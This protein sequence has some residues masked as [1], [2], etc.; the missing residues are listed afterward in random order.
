MMRST[1][2]NKC[3]SRSSLFLMLIPVSLGLA[4]WAMADEA[5]SPLPVSE[6]NRTTSVDFNT[7]ILPLLKQN[8]LAC[9]H[10]KEAE[11]GLV[12]ETLDSILKGGDSGP[13]LVAGKSAES[14][15]FSRAVG[16]DDPLM[17]PEDN[18]VG[19]KP[20]NPEQLG[21]LKLWIDQGAAAGKAKAIETITWQPIPEAMRT[22]YAL[23]LSP[24]GQF[25]VVGRGNRVIVVD[26]ATHEVQSRLVDPSLKVGEV[27]DV[28]LIQ[29]VAISPQADFIATGG[30]RTVRLWHKTARVYPD[31]EVPFGNA[32]G[33][34]AVHPNQELA[35]FVNAIGDIEVWNLTEN[36]RSH[37]LTG[38]SERI[39]DLAWAETPDALLSVDEMGNITQW[40]LKT[41][42]RKIQYDAGPLTSMTV[43]PDGSQVALINV[44]G[45]PQLLR[46]NAEATG[47]E[48][49]QESLGGL[50]EATAIAFVAKPSLMTVVATGNGT[51]SFV[52]VADNKIV[53]KVEHGAPVTAIEISGDQ[54]R[55]V[56]NSWRTAEIS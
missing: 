11:G 15:L 19:A 52:N 2:A 12:L 48:L 8:C 43:T 51:V 5:D 18:S 28:D 29:S 20:L 56:Q 26:T 3:L 31:S 9:H 45:K 50:T 14:L 54:L 53:R 34:I 24:D 17:P 22:V 13:A 25:A 44:E 6:L 46:I 47:F 10:A 40:D 55:S 36:Q 33:V 27:T 32:A 39:I 23:Q 1:L 49:Q 38:N 42:S 35:A 16:G 4:A 7:E 37:A 30:F 21:L 41:G